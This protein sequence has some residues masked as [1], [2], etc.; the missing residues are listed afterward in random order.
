MIFILN[1]TAVCNTICLRKS[2]TIFINNVQFNLLRFS[3]ASCG[4][5][6]IFS[7][8]SCPGTVQQCRRRFHVIIID[9]HNKTKHKPWAAYLIRYAADF[10]CIEVQYS[11]IT[12]VWV[13]TNYQS[14]DRLKLPHSGKPLSLVVVVS[15]DLWKFDNPNY[16]EGIHWGWVPSLIP[17]AVS[18][19]WYQSQQ[20]T[21][22]LGLHLNTRIFNPLE[23]HW[24]WQ[25]LVN[26]FWDAGPVNICH[27]L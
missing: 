11:T 8:F 17:A 21:S 12:R 1:E 27:D 6:H 9:D 16:L 22:I 24:V 23:I 19:S 7:Y 3:F 13:Y 14:R 5:T 18:N 4:F 26:V 15:A 25:H 10:Q 2:N 20:L